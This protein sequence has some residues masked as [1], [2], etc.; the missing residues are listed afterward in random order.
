VPSTLAIG[1]F[2]RATHLSIKTLRHYHQLGLLVPAEIDTGSGYRRYSIEQIPTAQVIRRFRD[3][4]M[5]LERIGEV[6]VA[7]DL[8]T[9]NDIIAG[10]LARLEH[11]LA[12]TQTAVASL[13][14]LLEG[15]PDSSRIEHRSEH[16]IASAAISEVVDLEDLSA[17][18]QGALGEI[19]ATLAAQNV[20][21]SGAAGGVIS[22]DFF[23]E[24]RGDIIMFVPAREPV[25]RIGRVGPLALPAVELA[26]I[27]HS[28]SHVDI[29]RAYGALAAYVSERALGVDGPIRE[30]YLVGHH[31]SEKMTKWRT[32]VAWPIF[33]TAIPSAQSAT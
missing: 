22:N 1:D 32:E 26:T 33:H 27:V 31:N 5:P 15:P 13:R 18:F 6:L 16:E 9:R 20:A 21:P 2:A 14:S 24:E 12:E 30:R 29:D 10:H 23:A 8:A 28:G 7:P 11:S 3:L 25:R 19:Y 17:W 4:D